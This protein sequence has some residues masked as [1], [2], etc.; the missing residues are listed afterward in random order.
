MGGALSTSSGVGI[1]L[2]SNSVRMCNL[3]GVTRAQN[4][5]VELKKLKD[6][7]E[8]AIRD[9]DAQARYDLKVERV[10]MV[11]RWTKA[12]CDSFLAMAAEFSGTRGE[13]VKT[14]YGVTSAAADSVTK[15][16]LGQKGDYASNGL[17]MIKEAS[18]APGGDATQKAVKFFVQTSA[19]KSEIIINAMNAKPEEVLKGAREYMVELTK[20]TFE[21][22][23]LKA[24]KQFTTIA[25][26]AFTYHENLAALV[27]ETVENETNIRERQMGQLNSLRSLARR[28]QQQIDALQT[29]VDSCS[30]NP[31]LN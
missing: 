14:T 4:S 6:G 12:T 2:D 18:S 8:L 17:K 21:A 28:I 30:F 29:F 13:W 11:L 1:V 23:E 15:T 19:I 26:E 25:S 16:V 3:A 27:D 10:F 22:L 31:T 20:F 9:V 7:L 24:A 5:V